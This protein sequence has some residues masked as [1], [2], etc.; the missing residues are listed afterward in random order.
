MCET[1][2]QI[3]FIHPIDPPRVGGWVPSV[4]G[5]G[6]MLGL[7]TCWQSD[8]MARVLVGAHGLVRFVFPRK[9]EYPWPTG[10]IWEI[11][12]WGTWDS[13][14]HTDLCPTIV[15]GQKRKPSCPG[16]F[17]D[18]PYPSSIPKTHGKSEA[19]T[20]PG[21]TL[22]ILGKRRSSV[23]RTEDVFSGT[24]SLAWW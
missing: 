10:S 22:R 23:P 2:E 9:L 12:L 19:G 18:V 16:S 24:S 20:V 6:I 21:P 1:E 15:V 11:H 8:G 13:L 7:G 17:P 5:A 4:S 3:Q 14:A